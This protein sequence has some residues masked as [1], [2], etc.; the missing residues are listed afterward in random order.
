MTP[1]QLH[2]RDLPYS[3]GLGRQWLRVELDR[4]DERAKHVVGG[5][6]QWPRVER[7]R[8]DDRPQ[9]HLMARV[10]GVRGKL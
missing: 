7:D 10:R 6:R 5:W 9:D 1:R 8:I 2:V 3:R 4:I